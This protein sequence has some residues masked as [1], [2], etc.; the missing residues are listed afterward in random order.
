MEQYE[1]FDLPWDRTEGSMK[2]LGCKTSHLD[3]NSFKKLT[4]F[5]EGKLFHQLQ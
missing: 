4:Q 2:S 1:G 3:F 5:V